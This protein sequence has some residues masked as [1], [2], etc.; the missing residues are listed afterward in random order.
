MYMMFYAFHLKEKLAE[1]P[2]HKMMA[3]CVLPSASA[4]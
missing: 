1:F 3:T 2:T 4:G